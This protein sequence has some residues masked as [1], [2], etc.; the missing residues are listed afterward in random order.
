[1]LA[2][3]ATGGKGTEGIAVGA[4]FCGFL[5][6]LAVVFDFLGFFPDFR[7]LFVASG[8]RLGSIGSG[9]VE[10]VEGLAVG[11]CSV[12]SSP[13]DPVGIDT[14]TGSAEDE[15]GGVD[16]TC[17][18]SPGPGSVLK[19]RGTSRSFN[20]PLASTSYDMAGMVGRDFDLDWIGVN[21]KV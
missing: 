18:L 1:M 20:L 14:G 8:S 6:A 5:A 3:D 9:V 4:G 10:D 21:V 12:I 11:V 16:F 19:R 7:S 17:S 13:V 2:D 15:E